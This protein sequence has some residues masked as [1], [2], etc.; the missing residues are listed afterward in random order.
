MNNTIESVIVCIFAHF[1]NNIL[2]CGKNCKISFGNWTQMHSIRF[3]HFRKS[4]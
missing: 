2:W 1:V 4:L 3:T